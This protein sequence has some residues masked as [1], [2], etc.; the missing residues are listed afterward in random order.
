[1]KKS[2]KI[3]LSIA[4][5]FTSLGVLASCN[6][7]CSTLDTSN[8]RYGYDPINTSFYTSKETAYETLLSSFS[9]TSNINQDVVLKDNLVYENDEGTFKY[10]DDSS[11]FEEKLF[12]T[13]NSSLYSVNSGKLKILKATNEENE[14]SRTDVVYYVG[15][16]SFT[17][18][19]FSAI[20][21]TSY[22]YK[23]PSYSVIDGMDR[24]LLEEICTYNTIYSNLSLSSLSYDKLYGYSYEDFKSYKEETDSN[25]KTELLNNLKKQRETNSLLANFGYLKHYSLSKDDSGNDVVDYT[26]KIKKWNNELGL[27]LEDGAYKIMSSNYLSAYETKLSQKVGQVKTCISVNDGFY[28]SISDDPLNATI[29]ITGKSKDFW[30][31]WGK[32]FSEHGFLEGLLV[33]PIGVLVEN[34]SHSF[35]MN[36]WGQI[37]ALVLVTVIVRLLLMLVS[38]PST[39]SQSKMT[40]LQ[41]EIQKLQQKYPNAQTNQYDKQR[42]AQAQMALYK[43]NG[44][45]PY[46]SFLIIFIQFPLFICVWNALSGSASLATDSVLGLNLSASILNTLQSFTNWPNNPGWW[47]A[48]VLIILMSASQIISM[49]LPNWLTKKRN[50]QVAKM[51]KSDTMDSQAKQMK[52]MQW[53]MT[54]FIIFMGFSLPAAMGAYWFI[55][56]LFSM[57]QSLLMHIILKN[58]NKKERNK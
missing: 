37:G 1:M 16:N 55:G 57:F 51:N 44:V 46:R 45:H 38:F 11:I 7:F 28:G 17:G 13:Y 3:A 42:L 5:G 15:I 4:L 50:K 53:I 39:L 20:S 36:G 25:K 23:L 27:E 26:A 8:F 6:S 33:Y 18:E 31:D 32:A 9:S 49:M 58:K 35:G 40:E 29:K 21:S 30:G 2:R 52:Y 12:K 22:N 43:K 56:A 34:L 14:E 54:I 48:L 19:M 41:P 47:S 24:K 10:S